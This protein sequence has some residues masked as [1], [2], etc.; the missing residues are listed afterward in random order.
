MPEV[1]DTTVDLD[2]TVPDYHVPEPEPSDI[3]LPD[4]V[5]QL[6]DFNVY[7]SERADEHV[8]SDPIE[9]YKRL[10]ADYLE[11]HPGEDPAYLI[12]KNHPDVWQAYTGHKVPTPEDEAL[13]ERMYRVF[14]YA[15]VSNCIS[16]FDCCFSRWKAP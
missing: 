15:K 14:D 13:E 9:D 4:T 6:P 11:S 7:A 16:L 1:P 8:F 2:T 10:Y 3:P 12:Q 5:Y